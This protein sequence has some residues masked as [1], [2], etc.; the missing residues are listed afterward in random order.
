M[1]EE[2]IFRDIEKFENQE[3][4]VNGLFGDDRNTAENERERMRFYDKL[5]RKYGNSPSEAVQRMLRKANHKNREL[6][7]NR[8]KNPILRL[9][10]AVF[11][12]AQN[13]ALVRMDARKQERNI[14][15]MMLAIANMGI[16]I[17]DA[18][19]RSKM[20]QDADKMR[21]TRTEQI[22]QDRRLDVRIDAQKTDNGYTAE[23]YKA[24]IV[25]TREGNV[26]SV[27]LSPR[28]NTLVPPKMAQRLLEGGT[29]LHKK[30]NGDPIWL[31]C[32]FNDKDAKGNI[33][34][35]SYAYDSM[36]LQNEL[37]KCAACKKLTEGEKRQLIDKLE[38]G[39]RPSIPV[40]KDKRVYLQA[41]PHNGVQVYEDKQCKQ[42]LD[43]VTLQRKYEAKLT[44]A[45]SERVIPKV[46]A[47]R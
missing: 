27:L 36:N 34:V 12:K 14:Q 5:N 17:S 2:Q 6:R 21:L 28:N 15:N 39:E 19:I 45:K 13:F 40:G 24:S 47:R 11:K 1:E 20:I 33:K 22:D 29:V 42:K 3:K 10:Y 30:H 4:R 26:K 7:R 25:D 23:E 31:T 37:D 8:I 9:F 46:K 18:E 32:D 16:D 43:P 38:N 41:K 44:V 35:K